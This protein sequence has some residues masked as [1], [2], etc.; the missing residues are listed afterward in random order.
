MR[1][2][3]NRLDPYAHLTRGTERPLVEHDDQ[4]TPLH[5]ERLD[6]VVRALLASGG[7]SVLDLGCGS[8]SLLVRLLADVRFT[9]VVGV[10]TS[11]ESMVLARQRLLAMDLAEGERL[12]LLDA[13]FL[14][15]DSRHADFDAAAMVETI[16]HIDPAQLS[17]VEN[18]VFKVARPRTVVITTPNREYNVRYGLSEG[19]MRHPDHRFEWTRQKFRRW[20]SGVASRC[21]YAVRFEEVGR[22]DPLLGSSTQMGI[23]QLEEGLLDRI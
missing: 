16:E 11:V 17:R 7:G 21:G 12:S 4:S 15:L 9:R 14:D 5:E 10:D 8:G 18:S 22:S 1:R 23:F 19:S 2:R 13:S 20:A 6:A 3:R